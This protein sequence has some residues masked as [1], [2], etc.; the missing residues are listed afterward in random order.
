MIL[1]IKKHGYNENLE[2]KL[3]SN[4]AILPKELMIL[5]LD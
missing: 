4:N 2:I 1:R 3:L 5:T